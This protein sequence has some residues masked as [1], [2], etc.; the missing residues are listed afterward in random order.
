M[1]SSIFFYLYKC[2]Q[3]KS[4]TWYIKATLEDISRYVFYNIV[5]H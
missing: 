4:S 5:S 3:L 1:A 2:Q